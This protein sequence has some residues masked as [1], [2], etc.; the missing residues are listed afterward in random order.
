[1]MVGREALPARSV[2]SRR[3]SSAIAG[4]VGDQQCSQ[5]LRVPAT[6]RDVPCADRF[7][8]DDFAPANRVRHIKGSRQAA[9][10]DPKMESLVTATS[11]FSI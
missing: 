2:E 5:S 7:H 4:G 8:V 11:H 6:S 9:L 3:T 1:M 10:H